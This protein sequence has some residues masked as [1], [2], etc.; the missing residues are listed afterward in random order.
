MIKKQVPKKKRERLGLRGLGRIMEEQRKVR[1]TKELIEAFLS[2]NEVCIRLGRWP[3]LHELE[4]NEYWRRFNRLPIAD[5]LTWA[6]L[7]V[8]TEW[9]PWEPGNDE[10]DWGGQWPGNVADWAEARPGVEWGVAPTVGEV[11]QEAPPPPPPHVDPVITVPKQ[12]PTPLPPHYRPPPDSRENVF[13]SEEV[14]TALCKRY[15]ILSELMAIA[16]DHLFV[17]GGSVL[18]SCVGLDHPKAAYTPSSPDLDLILVGCSEEE[19]TILLTK[20]LK[21]LEARGKVV[22]RRK[23][24]P[25]DIEDVDH[26]VFLSRSQYQV[27]V[28]I[29]VQYQ[30]VLA[31][32]SSIQE[33]LASADLQCCGLGFSLREGL[34]ALPLSAF[35]V[36]TQINI[37][38]CQRWSK[39]SVWLFS[40]LFFFELM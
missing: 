7:P 27:S 8:V 33:V 21:C 16:G 4:L 17:M 40:L 18:A 25:E 10:M 9:A 38:D 23:D 28:W 2:W 14:Y 20:M 32:A 31:L 36:V 12:P 34:V 3:L 22:F 11:L 37:V 29:D 24:D 19:A 35:C 1:I 30:V 13:S 26:R 5:D 6:P 39:V 15:P